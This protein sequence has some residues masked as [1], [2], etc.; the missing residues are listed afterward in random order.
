MDPASSSESESMTSDGDHFDALVIGAGVGGIAT[1]AR[2]TLAGYRTLLV[3]AL[4]RVGGRA[5]TRDVQGFLLNTG[6]LAIEFDGPVPKL[7]E[8]FGLHLDL[9]IPP[10]RRDSVVLW[11]GRQIDMGAGPIR[12]LRVA[13]PTILRFITAI[14]AFRP[15]PGQSTT[16]WFN[17][18]SKNE[19]V[20]GLL[21][22][23]LG[24][25]FA[26]TGRDLPAKSLVAYLI[27][28]SGFK[29]L[30]YPPGGTIEV[31]KPLVQAIEARGSRVWLNAPASELVIGPTGYVSGA[32]IERDG[33]RVTVGADV[34]VSNTGPLNTVRIA[35][36][37][38][39]PAGYAESVEQQTDGGAIITVH[40]AS[41]APLVDWP[42]LALAGKSR[43]FTYAGNYS[44][45]EHQR[46]K[47]GWYLY[48]AA[49][50]PRPARG[51]FDLESEKALLLADIRD[52]FHG[53]DDHA[54]VLAWDVTAHDWPAQRAI[55]GYDLPVETPIANLWNVGDGVKLG[56]DAG[57][58][59]CVRTAD[60]VVGQ[61]LNKFPL[62]SPARQGQNSFRQVA[63][64]G[65]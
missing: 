60:E 44:A 25:F 1:A 6:A 13:L 41:K 56:A 23:V 48:S 10:R 3:E 64:S 57:T 18:F 29:N 33:A 58:A 20:H 22:N 46:S 28:G 54:R 19:T 21:D 2:L 42:A 12:W 31:W 49:S 51:A 55:T 4:E 59:A 7:Y 53:F 35:G 63:D 38:N 50:T 26:A 47:P 32:V 43:R 39:F 17:R 40:F 61:I 16:E 37:Q 11:G 34:V 36:A 45:P 27:K 14:P 62:R 8:D 9:Y 52:H 5:S 15:R 24:G 30:G 65:S